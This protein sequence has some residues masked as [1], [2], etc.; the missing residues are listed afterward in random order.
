MA[1]TIL[2]VTR[3]PGNDIPSGCATPLPTIDACL[4]WCAATPFCKGI[5]YRSTADASCAGGCFLKRS[6]S[7]GLWGLNVDPNDSITMYSTSAIM[8]IV[9]ANV[10]KLANSDYPGNDQGVYNCPS[11]TGSLSDKATHPT[12]TAE[13]CAAGCATST[14]CAA[15]SYISDPSKPCRG[16]YLKNPVPTLKS[17]SSTVGITAG[18]V[19]GEGCCWIDSITSCHHGSDGRRDPLTWHTCPSASRGRM[20]EAC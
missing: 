13:M 5:T 16:C 11:D 10:T 15:Y 14:N 7:Q 18:V 2:P 20:S 17:D 12:M 8:P 4:Q 19:L 3:M 6:P 1:V 9:V